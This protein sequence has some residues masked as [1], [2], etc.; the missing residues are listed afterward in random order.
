MSSIH[1]THGRNRREERD[2][3][4]FPT[5]PSGSSFCVGPCDAQVWRTDHMLDSI[6]GVQPLGDRTTYT[7]DG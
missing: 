6:V 4:L 1:P 2:S 5:T 7:G 3:G